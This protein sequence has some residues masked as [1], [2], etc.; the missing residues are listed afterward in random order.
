MFH[1]QVNI[2]TR[3][4]KQYILLFFTLPKIIIS[5]NNKAKKEKIDAWLYLLFPAGRL[6]RRTVNVSKQM[7]EHKVGEIT[8]CKNED[9]NSISKTHVEKKKPEKLDMVTCIYSPYAGEIEMYT[10]CQGGQKITQL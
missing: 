1:S 3:N 10:W 9:L 7:E 8:Q 2:E 4:W 5:I 6:H